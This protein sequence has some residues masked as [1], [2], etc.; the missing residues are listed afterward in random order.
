MT[1]LVVIREARGSSGWQPKG[2]HRTSLLPVFVV[3]TDGNSG[4]VHVG[5]LIY[6]HIDGLRIVSECEE[7]YHV[8]VDEDTESR[9]YR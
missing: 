9:Q 6:F 2:V 3:V 5:R 4:K 1:L 7:I 8:D